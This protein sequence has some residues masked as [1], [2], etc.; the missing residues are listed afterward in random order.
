MDF[1]QFSFAELRSQEANIKKE[2]ERRAHLEI[3]IAREKIQAIAQTAGISLKSLLGSSTRKKNGP[4][5]VKYRHPE[6]ATQQWMGRGRQP[7]WVKEWLD[8]GKSLELL[9]V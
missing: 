1:T 3:A 5:T 2:L 7:K 4:P 8:S 6:N 9:H